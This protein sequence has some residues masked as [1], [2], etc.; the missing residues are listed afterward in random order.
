MTSS[1]S[2]LLTRPVVELAILLAFAFILLLAI[3]YPMWLGHGLSNRNTV[4]TGAVGLYPNDAFYYLALGPAEMTDEQKLFGEDKFIRAKGDLFINPIGNLIAFIADALAISNVEAFLIFRLLAA[5]LLLLS[6][7]TLTTLF[8]KTWLARILATALYL[9][10]AGYSGCINS[11]GCS[12]TLS[13]PE[14]N[15]F[16]AMIGEYYIPLANALFV[17]CAYV[18]IRFLQSSQRFLIPVLALLAFL[19]AAVY[20][21]GILV[22]LLLSAFLTAYHYWKNKST[23]TIIVFITAVL[24]ALPIIVYY[25][26]LFLFHMDDAARNEGWIQGP[27]LSETFLTYLWFLL[28]ILLLLPFLYCQS[29]KTGWTKLVPLLIWLIFTII[30]TLIPP[31]FLPFQVQ[32]HIGITAPMSVLLFMTLE[33][34]LLF[35][36]RLTTKKFVAIAFSVLLLATAIWP[37]ITF[38]KTILHNLYERSLPEFVEK[39]AFKVMKWVTKNVGQDAI[40]V[41]HDNRARMFAGITGCKVFYGN[42]MP[43]EQSIEFEAKRL[44][45]QGL[46]ENANTNGLLRTKWGKATH[47]FM[48]PDLQTE[49]AIDTPSSLDNSCHMLY[50][51]GEFSF[52]ELH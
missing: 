17:G 48:S 44:W 19:L 10:G 42:P 28:P 1:K 50:R 51:E 16:V 32:A 25:T 45:A 9:F 41:T 40:V 15:M 18:L 12:W 11:L 27:M 24:G 39:D 30:L 34:K 33:Q 21:Y 5:V 7:Y 29:R 8:L 6:F 37:N 26:W 20:I 31:P 49:L 2:Q 38:Y 13:A 35:Q 22:F 23:D 43:G 36:G 47:V 46:S 4:F 14:M 3:A 52:W